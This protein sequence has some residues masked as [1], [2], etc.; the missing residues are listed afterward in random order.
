MLSPYLWSVL[1]WGS[2]RSAVFHF[3]PRAG[4]TRGVGTYRRF[5][6]WQPGWWHPRSQLERLPVIPSKMVV[7]GSVVFKWD[8]L[9]NPLKCLGA[10]EGTY[11]Q[12]LFTTSWKKPEIR[13]SDVMV[14]RRWELHLP[15]KKDNKIRSERYFRTSPK[16]MFL[17]Q[18]FF[19]RTFQKLA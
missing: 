6:R 9:K 2:L 3:H 18:S 5:L 14:G 16:L 19:K 1:F 10:M 7:P 4:D 13:Q 11:H 8:D 17:Y 12:F 15:P